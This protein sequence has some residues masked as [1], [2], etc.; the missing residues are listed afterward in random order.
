MQ[1]V[2]SGNPKKYTLQG[3]PIPKAELE[4]AGGV[5]RVLNLRRV[6]SDMLTPEYK[7]RFPSAEAWIEALKK[8]PTI[9]DPKAHVRPDGVVS[10][11]NQVAWWAPRAQTDAGDLAELV[12]RLALDPS[13][14]PGG[15]V[16]I[17]LSPQA[18][19]AI[20]FRRPTALDGMPFK[21]FELPPADKVWGLTAKGVP[22]AVAPPVSISQS[23][24][25]ELVS[26]A[27]V[28]AISKGTGGAA[29]EGGAALEKASTK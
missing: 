6:Y 16:K 11:H 26:E 18:A 20:G 22:E 24:G 28:P 17:T 21:E 25:L 29:A 4:A 14:Y 3:P 8:D 7:A 1:E 13:F 15:A 27:A 19:G 5:T 9:F 2:V 12:E 23:A 10:G